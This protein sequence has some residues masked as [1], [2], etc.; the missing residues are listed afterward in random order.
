MRIYAN[1]GVVSVHA[2]LCVRGWCLLRMYA[3]LM[4][5]Y[6]RSQCCMCVGVCEFVCVCVC[7]CVTDAIAAASARGPLAVYQRSTFSKFRPNRRRRR[8]RRCARRA[9]ASSH[10]ARRLLDV[11][12][13]RTAGCSRRRRIAFRS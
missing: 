9:S 12:R 10:R 11:R 7:V 13:L 1:C 4:C 5:L 6:V 2:R 8:A 3:C